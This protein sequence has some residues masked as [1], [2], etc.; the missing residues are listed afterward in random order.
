VTTSPRLRTIPPEGVDTAG[1]WLFWAKPPD[2][3][4][5][6]SIADLGQLE[7]ILITEE[8]RIPILVAG[9][10]RVLACRL[11]ERE[12]LALPLGELEQTT[13]GRIYL[14]S[15]RQCSPGVSD[16]VLA[17]RYFCTLLQTKELIGL[18]QEIAGTDAGKKLLELI[19]TWLRLA[20]DW[21]ELLQS[22]HIPIQAAD[23]L[24]RLNPEDLFSLRQFFYDLRWSKNNA[25]RFLTWLEE[26]ALRERT[27]LTRLMESNGLQRILEQE[28]SP[29]DKIQRLVQRAREIRY[30]YLCSLEAELTSITRELESTYPWRISPDPSFE[31]D[32]IHLDVSL[33]TRQELQNSAQELMRLLEDGVLD[34]IWDWQRRRLKG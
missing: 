20:P 2:D 5:L 33:G 21:D 28:L 15:N 23:T 8:N 24:V 10:K 18:L 27:T 11:L 19:I 12:V 22:G 14:E 6:R 32:R 31:S 9:Y 29:K 26:A 25:L 17:G 13:K 7:P 16:L 34:R 4:F 30:P 1:S 3:A